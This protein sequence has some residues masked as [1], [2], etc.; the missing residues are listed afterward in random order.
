[1]D[2]LLVGP[3]KPLFNEQMQGNRTYFRNDN[4][5]SSLIANWLSI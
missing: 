4:H 3:E 1:M 2:L 5:Q